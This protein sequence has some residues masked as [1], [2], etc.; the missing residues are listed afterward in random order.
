MYVTFLFISARHEMEKFIE[1]AGSKFNMRTLRT[2]INNERAKFMR[3]K[4]YDLQQ[5]DIT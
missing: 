3:Q 4:N 1:N 5:M 2:K